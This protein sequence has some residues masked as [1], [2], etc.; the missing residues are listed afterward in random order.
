MSFSSEV[1]EEL[2]R[3][4]S[5]ARHCRLAEIMAIIRT[6]GKITISEDNLY[7]VIVYTENI[8]VARKYYNL[9]KKTFS[10]SPSI[11]VRK[12]IYLKKNQ[13]YTIGIFNHGQAV[14]ILKATKLLNQ[15]YDIEELDARAN[16]VIQQTCCK[17]AFIRGVFLASG[18]I[19]DPVKG[20]H[21]EIVCSDRKKAEQISEVISAFSLSSK[22]IKRKKYYIVYLKEGDMI[23]DILNVMQAS[24]ALMQLE[25]IRIW[26]EMRN[27]VNRRVNCETANLNKTVSAAM[28]QLEEIKFLRDHVGLEGLPDGLREIAVLR[29]EHTDASLKELGEMLDPPVGKSGV[30]HRL[31]K[32]G[33]M[34]QDLKNRYHI[35]G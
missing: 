9:I 1:K 31:R 11:S 33:Q 26:K 15:S 35:R 21:F 32:L 2:S 30:N 7:N 4:M 6:C 24:K 28:R 20:Y 34:A 19:S 3:Q 29:L 16:V 22:I 8:A 5:P 14:Q 18:S 12:N 25:N 23:V 10:W 27:S 13:I 17:R